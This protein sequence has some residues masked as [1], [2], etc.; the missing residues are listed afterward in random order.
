SHRRPRAASPARRGPPRP[1]RPRPGGPGQVGGKEASRTGGMAP[2]PPHPTPP[3]PTEPDLAAAVSRV[4]EA[5]PEPLT[6]SKIRAHLPAALRRVNLDELAASLRRRVEA[7]VLYEYGPY[8][9][10]QHRFWDRPRPVHVA[11][12]ARAS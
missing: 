11:A 8:R 6:L 2:T 12:L 7:N 4:L 9:S 1:G 3:P 10:Q 5:S